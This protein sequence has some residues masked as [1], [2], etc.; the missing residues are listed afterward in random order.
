MS[1]IAAMVRTS[2]LT[3]GRAD[4]RRIAQSLLMS[5]LAADPSHATELLELV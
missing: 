5:D 4:A 1:W 3:N 2:G